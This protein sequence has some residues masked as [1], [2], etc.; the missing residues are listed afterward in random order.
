VSVQ[1]KLNFDAG[2]LRLF[3]LPTLGF[4][5]LSIFFVSQ[6]AVTGYGQEREVQSQQAAQ[7]KQES[8]DDEK[9]KQSKLARQTEI[10]DVSREL[11]LLR[12]N[13]QIIEDLELVGFQYKELMQVQEDMRTGMRDLVQKI[14]A[15]KG[16]ERERLINEFYGQF[17]KRVD[18]ILLP[19]QAKR[20][21]Q[22]AIQSTVVREGK[23]NENG[24]L[25][26]PAV[27]AEVGISPE[28]L[29]KMNEVAK[30]EAEKI[31]KELEKMREE[32]RTNVLEILSD[33]Q[34]KKLEEVI[35]VRF[36]FQ[37]EYERSKRGQD[38]DRDS[39]DD[40]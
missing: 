18:E 20:L 32:A 12:G 30:Q 39:R 16:E 11:Y 3:R 25:N 7:S 24:L 38:R 8:Q 19:H 22:I 13:Q 27:I 15:V 4:A 29:K 1:Q 35:G 14:N 5:T 40:D 36:D 9:D 37:S 21:R 6:L 10:R 2:I 28:Q 33:Q 34:R 17:R 23:I 26:H 31:Q